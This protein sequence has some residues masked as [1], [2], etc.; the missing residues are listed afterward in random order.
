MPGSG[1]GGGVKATLGGQQPIPPNT[2]DSHSLLSAL[3][4]TSHQGACLEGSSPGLPFKFQQQLPV[5]GEIWV[6]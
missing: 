4:L 2:A 5:L 6:L 1:G 3:T